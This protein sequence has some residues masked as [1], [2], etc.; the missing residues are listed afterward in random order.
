ML[1]DL[2]LGWLT[3]LILTE[4]NEHT[5]LWTQMEIKQLEK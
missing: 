2:P 3:C 1:S 5:H 4:T